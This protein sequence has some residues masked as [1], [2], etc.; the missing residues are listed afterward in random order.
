[1]S[2]SDTEAESR[3]LTTDEKATVTGALTNVREAHTA[4]STTG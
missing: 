1:V 4:V 2:A 3:Y